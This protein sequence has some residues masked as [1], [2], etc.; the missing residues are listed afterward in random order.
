MK[1]NDILL[2]FM[3]V[4]M[5]ACEE[6]FAPDISGKSV[7]LLTPADG[8]ATTRTQLILWWEEIEGADYY[9]LQMVSPSFDRME[10]MHFDTNLTVNQFGV[11]LIDP[12]DYEWRVKAV[13]TAGETPYSTFSFSL[14]SA[15]S[16]T[17]VTDRQP[18]DG[19]FFNDTVIHFSWSYNLDYDKFLF[20]VY[21]RDDSLIF[22][23][24]VSEKF[25]ELDFVSLG[26][27]AESAFAWNVQVVN[28]SALSSPLRNEF[29]IDTTRP[30]KPVLIKPQNQSTLT[31]SL[32]QF[33]W[34]FSLPDNSPVTSYL[35]FSDDSLFAENP[36]TFEIKNGLTLEVQMQPGR[37]FWRVSATDKADNNSDNSDIWSFTLEHEE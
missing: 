21:N 22:D 9:N 3:L 10:M 8:M 18:A 27:F 7:V 15:V 23:K 33:E 37:Y 6:I 19:Q 35:E 32:V 34:Q 36:E 13:N 12:D 1:K 14:D 5:S 26:I 4:F 20:E 16:V 28:G 29:T 2:I 30:P 11:E 24:S 25:V 17:Q 31:D